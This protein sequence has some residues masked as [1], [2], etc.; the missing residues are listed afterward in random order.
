MTQDELIKAG[1]AELLLSTSPASTM[2]AQYGHDWHY[3]P[4]GSHWYKAFKYFDQAIQAVTAITATV[5]ALVI[6]FTVR[7]G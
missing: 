5:T 1:E 4:V 2:I 3:W 6:T 7:V